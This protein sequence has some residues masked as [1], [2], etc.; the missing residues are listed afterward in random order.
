MSKPLMGVLT[1]LALCTVGGAQMAQGQTL[2]G[3][4][5]QPAVSP[6]LLVRGGATGYYNILQPQLQFNSALNQLAVQQQ[7][8]SAGSAYVDGTTTGHP[9]QF[10]NYSHFY[11]Q[12]GTT[13]AGQG[14]RA[15]VTSPTSNSQY[16]N[17]QNTAKSPL[18]TSPTPFPKPH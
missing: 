3:N 6:Y 18:G 7:Q 17:Q 16:G 11:P 8:G 4:P 15:Q 10:N 2:Y 14:T 12:R 1:V 5:Y 9:I 13:I